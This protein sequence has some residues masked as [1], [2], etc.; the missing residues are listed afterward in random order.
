MLE[1][2][3]LIDSNSQCLC[4]CVE[5]KVVHSQVP[6]SRKFLLRSRTRMPLS[7]TGRRSNKFNYENLSNRLEF[8]HIFGVCVC[9]RYTC[10]K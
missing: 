7:V 1:K 2:A 5:F 4:E 9:A 3:R 10:D 6:N 8:A